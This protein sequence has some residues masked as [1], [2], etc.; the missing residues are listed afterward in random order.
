MSGVIT[1]SAPG[2][3]H[4][5]WQAPAASYPVPD[6]RC[7]RHSN[8]ALWCRWAADWPSRWRPPRRRC[9]WCRWARCHRATRW[10]WAAGDLRQRRK[11]KRNKNMRSVGNRAA[12]WQLDRLSGSAVSPLPLPALT[13][14][15]LTAEKE[16]VALAKGSSHL[17]DF[18]ALRIKDAWLLRRHC[19]RK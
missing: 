10:P 1:Y 19:K 18:L 15:H 7:V 13:S 6:T 16:L 5:W 9:D 2:L 3:W 12:N 8:P 11:K 14:S 17:W 4:P